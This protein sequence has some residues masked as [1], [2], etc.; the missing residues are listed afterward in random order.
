MIML[1]KNYGIY[2]RFNSLFN[3]LTEKEQIEIEDAVVY[4]M[5][6]FNKALIELH[7]KIPN[8]LYNKIDARW[9]DV[10]KKDREFVEYTLKNLQ[11][12]VTKEQLEDVLMNSKSSFRSKKRLI[13]MLIGETQ[14][15]QKETKILIKK[16]LGLIPIDE[17]KDEE[18]KSE[19]LK[20]EDLLDD[21]QIEDLQLD[22][23]LLDDQL[24]NTQTELVIIPNN[25]IG[26]GDDIDNGVDANIADNIDMKHVNVQMTEE[27]EQEQG[28]EERKIEEEKSSYEP[29]DEPPVNAPTTDTQPPPV[30]SSNEENQKEKLEDK[31]KE[32][33][34]KEKIEDNVPKVTPLSLDSKKKV[35]DET[36]NDSIIIQGPLDMDN[37]SATELMNI[38]TVM[39]SHS[40]KKRLLEQQK[41]VETIQNAV[42][43]LSSLLPETDTNNFST[44]IDK[45]R[46]LYYDVGEQMNSLEDATYMSV[47]KN[48]KKKRTEQLMTEIDIG[49]VSLT[50]N[51]DYLKEALEIGGKI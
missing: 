46:Q 8:S 30:K 5:D 25:D 4:I 13:R 22:E 39:Q 51:K 10:M 32:K 41:E 9:K 3:H 29:S 12:E 11:L 26:N 20:E 1:I 15:V 28:Q 21:V 38:A 34:E 35:D 42:E 7:G 48:Y 36:D 31:D 19:T 6:K 50:V 27:Q 18:E 43:I 23:I 24:V 33:E 14:S 17:E 16:Y 2:K 49:K 44:P 47:E 40:Q 37:L 45:L